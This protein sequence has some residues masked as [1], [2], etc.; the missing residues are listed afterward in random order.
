L[1]TV[2]LER[3]GE[4]TVLAALPLVLEGCLEYSDSAETGVALAG[5]VIEEVEVEVVV[6]SEVEVQVV[7]VVQADP[8]M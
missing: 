8:Q 7:G 1:V 4:L 2:P 6:F 5:N 3:K